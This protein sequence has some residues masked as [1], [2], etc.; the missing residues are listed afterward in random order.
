MSTAESA[1]NEFEPTL[2]PPSRAPFTSLVTRA[3]LLAFA[4]RV[5]STCGRTATLMPAGATAFGSGEATIECNGIEFPNHTQVQGTLLTL[6]GLGLRTVSTLKIRLYVAALYVAEP[7]NDPRAILESSAPNEIIIQFIHGVSARE[8]RKSL[9]EELAKNSPER[10]PALEEGLQQLRSWAVDV[11]SG[12]R[13]IFIRTPGIGM[14]VDINGTVKGSIAGDDFAKT[15]L[16]IWL[17]DN[18]QTPELK[19]GLLGAPCG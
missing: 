4:L 8:L 3:S 16:S 7:S 11:K 12:Q 1:F 17:G 15:F 6:N 5:A 13:I 10:S 2:Q 19:R 9:E 18:P 14:E